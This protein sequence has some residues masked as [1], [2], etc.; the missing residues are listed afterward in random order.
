V[1]YNIQSD[2]HIDTGR[3]SPSTEQAQDAF[4]FGF[5]GR[6]TEAKGLKRL[7]E[8]S[9]LMS[10][11]NWQLKI[12]GDTLGDYAAQLM[13]EYP[14]TRIEWLGRV[15]SQE[16]YGAVDVVVV[17]SIWHDPLPYVVVETFA[18]G[19]ALICANSGGIPEL[20]RMG[21]QVGSYPADDTPELARLLDEAVLN[22]EQWRSGGFCDNRYRD[23]FSES[24]VN[25]KYSAVYSG[26][27]EPDA[28]GHS[29]SLTHSEG[30]SA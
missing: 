21:K 6:I 24:A 27:E 19:K 9:R 8:A 18:A 1:I 10:Q 13:R 2:I 3:V 20:A 23:A 16:F 15:P 7:L 26:L 12:A 25:G 29:T 14:D 22:P 11:R 5:I 4:V 30:R 17:P 28:T